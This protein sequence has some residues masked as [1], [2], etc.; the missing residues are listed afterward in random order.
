MKLF[1]LIFIF[2]NFV[3]CNI[4][5]TIKRAVTDILEPNSLQPDKSFDSSN[6][7]NIRVLPGL[8]AG[9]CPTIQA[10]VPHNL[11]EKFATGTW[12]WDWYLDT[13]YGT[14]WTKNR[15]RCLYS[16][17]TVINNH[18]NSYV[19][20]AIDSITNQQ[21]IDHGEYLWSFDGTI[22][23]MT[24]VVPGPYYRGLYFGSI[25]VSG[26]N[27]YQY[28]ASDPDLKDYII[29][30]SCSEVGNQHTAV[31]TIS[32]RK[33]VTAISAS[34]IASIKLAIKNNPAIS[35]MYVYKNDP[36]CSL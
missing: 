36:N 1:V 11:M 31:G 21:I 17:L 3:S 14:L 29:W 32:T 18:T 25:G 30:Y 19:D 23:E 15:L 24:S 34:T 6:V 22:L 2:V 27:Y 5:I 26:T 20:Y 12:H 4:H 35:E 33:P 13:D 8:R 7:E 28:V 10:T 9:P 16:N